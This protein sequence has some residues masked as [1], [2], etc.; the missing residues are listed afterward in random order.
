MASLVGTPF[1]QS[2]SVTWIRHGGSDAPEE[3]DT[4]EEPG[5][6]EKDDAHCGGDETGAN[7]R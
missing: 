2:T 5:E 3:T 1:A 6:F 7:D 4:R